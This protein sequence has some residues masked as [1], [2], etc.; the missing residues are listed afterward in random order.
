MRVLLL[1]LTLAT[2]SGACRPTG[3]D[4][5]ASSELATQATPAPSPTARPAQSFSEVRQPAVAGAFYPADPDQARAMVDQYL[6]PVQ[7]LDGE[8]IALIVPHAGWVYSGHVA[9]FA[10]KQIEGLDYDAVV[11]VAPNH[12]DPGFDAISV[13]ARGAFETPLGLVPV[14]EALV[15]E[16]LAAHERIVFQRDVHRQEHSIEV[17]LPFL[18]R[19]CPDCAIVP[20]LIGRPTP[21][22]LEL[23]TGAL[24]DVLR[25]RKALL[26]AS[27]D[28]SHY[29][30]YDDAVRVDTT[31]LAA[32]E[33]MDTGLVAEVLVAQMDQGV[34]GLVTCA[35]GEG[36]IL[37]VMRVAQALGADH[38]RVLRYANS[39]DVGGD[40]TRVV[41]Y[42]AAMFWHWQPPDLTGA[43]QVELLSIA[44]RSLEGQLL[45]GEM[46]ALDPPADPVLSRQLGA[47]VTLELGGELRG[48][49]GH[50]HGDAPL[51]QTVAQAAVD[52]A[53][54]DPRFPPLPADQLGDVEI[55]VSLLSP[56]KRVRDVH[57]AAEIEVGRHGLYLLYG[58]QRGVLLPQVPVE[59]G[60]ERAEFL[61]QICF[62]AGLPA[63]CWERAT[64]YTFTA[65]VFGE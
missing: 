62:K 39:G 12:S 43:Q 16:L 2:F 15:D 46:L 4:T 45:K 53:V 36:P 18:Q 44:R 25:D 31:T 9:A 32:I 20:V 3:Q 42:G 59:Q 10:Y 30:A 28:L 63:D 52:A 7:P 5:P 40:L 19:V 61:Q 47:F 57:D 41:G 51:Y 50:V 24:T 21:E 48:C 29:P 35:C 22:N 33:T 17:Q 54:N 34:P 49:I 65:K 1:L 11:I 60:W 56:F 8:P 38:V 27:S 58:Q 26:I 64:L 55:E 23:L 6:A 37:V 13:Y 14:D